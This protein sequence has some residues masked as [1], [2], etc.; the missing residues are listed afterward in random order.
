MAEFQE[1]LLKIEGKA[2]PNKY[3]TDFMST[4]HQAQDKDSYQDI[5]GELHREILPHT[6]TKIEFNTPPMFMN[7]KQDFQSYFPDRKAQ[8]KINVEY[9]DDEY[10]CY[11]T[12]IFY[13]PDIQY[14]IKRIAGSRIEYQQTRIALIEY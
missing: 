8:P 10:N 9:W 4:P 14:K 1:Y 13:T 11:A 7:E 6:R 3:I 12:G 2:V 5:T